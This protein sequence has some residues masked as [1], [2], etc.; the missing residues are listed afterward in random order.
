MTYAV[1]KRKPKKFRLAGIHILAPEI[2]GFLI[3]AY[4]KL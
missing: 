2:K 4:Y 3:T 1:V